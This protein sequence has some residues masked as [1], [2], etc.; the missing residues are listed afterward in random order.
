ML[1]LGTR[2]EGGLGVLAWVRPFMESLLKYESI[3]SCC[4]NNFFRRALIR[5][6]SLSSCLLLSVS[7]VSDG[8]EL[9]TLEES[10]PFLAS[11]VGSTLA[12]VV[13]IGLGF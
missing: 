11:T 3:G 2:G 13:G 10:Q 7:Q 5:A 9:L 6:I 4:F 12:S 1:G 8:I